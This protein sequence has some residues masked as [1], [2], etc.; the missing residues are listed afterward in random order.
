MRLFIGLILMA[1][2]MPVFSY[3]Q[4]NDVVYDSINSTNLVLD[5]FS[6]SV[7]RQAVRPALVFIHGG[8]FSMGSRKDIP[9][10]IKRL[11]DDGFTVFSVEYRLAPKDPY[12]AAVDDVRAA[13][14]FIRKN[15]DRFSVDPE[16]ISVHGESAGG[17]LAVVLGV[18]KI[19]DREGRV[20]EL[21]DPVG[22]VSDWFGRTDFTATQTTGTDCAEVF[23]GKKRTPE[24]LNDF[25]EASA[26][27]IVLKNP[28][29]FLVIHGSRDQQVYPYHSTNLVNRLWKNAAS[30]DFYVYEN[31]G[32]GFPRT[33]PWQITRNALLE[34]AFA[35]NPAKPQSVQ[36]LPF[37]V[38]TDSVLEGSYNVDVVLGNSDRVPV[39]LREKAD[40]EGKVSVIA[41]S[42]AATLEL[43]TSAADRASVSLETISEKIF[44]AP[45]SRKGKTRAH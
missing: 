2:S 17:Y 31:Q 6:P 20:D 15:A 14:R 1:L 8:C 12:P 40:A 9:E 37:R 28:A 45:D 22:F 42:K 32:H 34:F 13:I 29:K 30:A 5:V 36:V 35:V 21:S 7:K 43:K 44:R 4:E 19:R 23:L 3:T 16:K 27:N 24:T 26:T 18:R 41:P 38:R 25:I 10:E 39:V 11:A 33:I